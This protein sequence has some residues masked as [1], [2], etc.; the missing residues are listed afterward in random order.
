MHD[1]GKYKHGF[2]A[3]TDPQLGNAAKSVASPPQLRP[4]EK[5]LTKEK[6]YERKRQIKLR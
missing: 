2:S 1:Q 6:Q 3:I 4:A 5:L